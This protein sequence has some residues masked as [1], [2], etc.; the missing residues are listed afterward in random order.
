[1]YFV[2]TAGLGAL[3][4]FAS[5]VVAPGARAHHGGPVSRVGA[6]SAPLGARLHGVTPA[7]RVDLGIGYGATYFDRTY[8]GDSPYA[9]GSLGSVLV[10]VVSLDGGVT[11]G[12]GTTLSAT[13][14]A[15]VVESDAPDGARRSE[16]GLGDLSFRVSQDLAA[17]WDPSDDRSVALELRVG[18]VAPT[19]RYDRTAALTVLGLQ[20]GPG[21]AL[22]P[23]TYDARASLGAGAWSLSG[24]A[25]VVGRVAPGLGLEAGV[26]V[27]APVEDTPD[28]I[29]W[30]ADL[31]AHVGATLDLAGGALAVSL[32][33]DA[34]AHAADE[35]PFVD[36][37][38]HEAGA[39]TELGL[40]LGVFARPVDTLSCGLRAHVPVYQRV[41]GVQLVE[42]V[43]VSLACGV[44]VALD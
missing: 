1:V 26:G 2:R 44:G 38:V 23:T 39:R 12:S 40:Q 4:A 42:T 10:H 9:L 15:G 43:S 19:G 14:P 7:P 11:L 30:G 8:E 16:S 32:G 34:R 5:L 41:D 20:A 37:A 36:G 27:V 21:G 22:S 31:T 24:G 18:A 13:L 25:R 17:L 29:R 35:I 33:A 3:V 6:P 28:D